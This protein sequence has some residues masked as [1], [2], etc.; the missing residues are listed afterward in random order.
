MLL[1]TVEDKYD[2][3]LVYELCPGKTMNEHLF[4]VCSRG[5]IWLR[6]P[7]LLGKSQTSESLSQRRHGDQGDGRRRLLFLEKAHHP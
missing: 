4:D 7:Q 2:I 6:F 1:A 3:W 5:V